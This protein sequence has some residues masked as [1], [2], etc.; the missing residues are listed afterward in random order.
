MGAIAAAEEERCRENV[1]SRAV[2]VFEEAAVAR[3]RVAKAS[4]R[5]CE[6]KLYGEKREGAVSD[7]GSGGGVDVL[8]YQAVRSKVLAVQ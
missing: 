1:A 6:V 8:Y 7:D 4:I 3:V 5:C 2:A